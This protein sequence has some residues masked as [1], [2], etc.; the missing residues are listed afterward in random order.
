MRLEFD[1]RVM[2]MR[3]VSYLKLVKAADEAGMEQSM[4]MDICDSPIKNET[5]RRLRVVSSVSSEQGGQN[6]IDLAEIST[7]PIWDY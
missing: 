1:L 5:T 7:D 6:V 2:Q 3:R 4:K